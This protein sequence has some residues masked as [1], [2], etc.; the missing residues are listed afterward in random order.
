MTGYQRDRYADGG[1]E[2]NWEKFNGVAKYVTLNGPNLA[3]YFISG[4]DFAK[5]YKKQSE[6]Y[7]KSLTTGGNYRE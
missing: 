7:K 2:P 1:N 6:L 4:G 5:K 3:R